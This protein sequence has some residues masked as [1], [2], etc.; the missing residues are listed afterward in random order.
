[1]LVFELEDPHA[2]EQAL[3]LALA[4]A[5]V[6]GLV[7]TSAAAGRPLPVRGDRRAGGRS[8]R[9][10]RAGLRSALAGDA[11]PGARRGQPARRRS[12]RCAAP[13]TRPAARS[14]RPRSPTATRPRS[15]A[16]RTSAR[17]RCCSRSR[18]TTRCAC[19]ATACWS[20]SSAPR[21]STAASSCARSRPSSSTT[22]TGSGRP[23]Q[24]YCHRHT[25][26]YRIRKIEELTGPRPLARHA[27]GSSSGSRFER[28]SW[29]CDERVGWRVAGP[30]APAGRS[31]RRSCAIS[32]SRTR[33]TACCCSTSTTRAPST[34]PSLHG[35]GKARA[36][37]A[38]ARAR[39]RPTPSRARS[40]A[41]TC[42]STR[43]A[44]GSTS[45]RWRP[46]ST[47]GCHYLDLG[48]L[49]WM[50]GRQLELGRRFERAGPARP[51]RHR[52]GPGQDEPDGGCE[53]SASSATPVERDAT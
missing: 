14:R 26:R 6:P 17:S 41:A 19:T 33:S 12:A 9:G 15:P 29:S 34:S 1:M 39:R 23:A 31:R 2:A 13:S 45:T 10:R 48:G 36:A 18:T 52:L 21:A 30:R 49:Y 16:I 47:A 5:G 22:A 25:L 50:T 24:L 27:T 40:R 28:G 46:A 8:G 3:E 51:A 11:R 43:P 44:T 53:R 4:D 37:R 42:S 20:R 7:A 38:D 32:P 35:G